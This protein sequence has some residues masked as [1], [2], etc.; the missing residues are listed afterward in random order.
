M[1]R[2]KAMDELLD[3]GCQALE[4]VDPAAFMEWRRRVASALGPDHIY[5]QLF[6]DREDTNSPLTGADIH[7]AS[8]VQGTAKNKRVA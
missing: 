7:S 6:Q 3:A 1:E 2:T 8:T 5:A 4:G